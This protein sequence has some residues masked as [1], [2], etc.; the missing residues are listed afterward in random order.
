[1][2]LILRLNGEKCCQFV[3]RVAG[4]DAVEAKGVVGLWKS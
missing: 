2:S 1:M 4:W 3:A